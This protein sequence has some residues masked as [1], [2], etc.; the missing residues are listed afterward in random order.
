MGRGCLSWGSRF[1]GL[2]WGY[3]SCV[4]HA[5]RVRGVCMDMC[6]ACARRSSLALNER[7]NL[8]RHE[9]QEE[10]ERDHKRRE[11][12]SPEHRRHLNRLRRRPEIRLSSGNG[13]TH[14]CVCVH[15]CMQVCMH[16]C[17]CSEVGSVTMRTC[18]HAH[19]RTC[20]HKLTTCNTCTTCSLWISRSRPLVSRSFL[21]KR[22]RC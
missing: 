15:A 16:V 20:A 17:A 18:A 3:A 7:H 21:A 14:T 5:R 13:Y 6:V 11:V 2:G 19:P 22:P 1:R 12:D 4:A 9:R 10:R 8:A